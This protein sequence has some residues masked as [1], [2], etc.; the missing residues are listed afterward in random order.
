MQRGRLNAGIAYGVDMQCL[1]LLSFDRRA[2]PHVHPIEYCT[3]LVTLDQHEQ[4]QMEYVNSF[5][6]FYWSYHHHRSL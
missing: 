5:I 2:M 1:Q 6:V 4:L 3:F